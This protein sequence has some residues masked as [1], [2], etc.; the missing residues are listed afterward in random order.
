MRRGV[1]IGLFATLLVACASSPGVTA[2]QRGD[3]AALSAYIKPLYDKGKIDN[4]EAARI[5]KAE[6]ERELSTAKDKDALE[7]LRDAQPCVA[8]I[9]PV[10]QDLAKKHDALGAAAALALYETGN[11]SATRAREWTSDATPEWRAVG[12]RA[13][14]RPEDD[15]ARH[16]ALVDP[17]PEVRRASMRA[18]GQANDPR[19]LDGLFEAARLDPEPMARNEAVRAIARIT[20]NDPQIANRLRDLWTSSDDAVR[21][22]IASAYAAPSIAS[23]GGAEA[24][25][26]LVAAGHGP[27]VISGAAAILWASSHPSNYDAETRASALALLLRTIDSGS[28]RDRS[29]ALAVVPTDDPSA[30]LALQKAS[31]DEGDV[32]VRISA[33]TRLLEVP[34]SRTEALSALEQLAQPDADHPSTGQ[35]ARASLARAGDLHVQAWI[36]KDLADE[37]ASVRLGAVNALAALG[38]PARG[39]PLLA[40]ADP[41]VRTR[42]ACT[43]VVAA[44][45]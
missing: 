14:V 4:D 30:V 31:K 13:L 23:H 35:R 27:G 1:S 24:L 43:I 29:F 37:D 6:L 7:R 40:D 38:R 39:A 25:R 5:A 41:R 10:L 9:E 28:R 12:V 22:D 11:V 34:T 33:L 3:R 45:K 32:D 42:A 16:V 21:E 36:E 2:A 18:S 17:S 8:E 20:S 44:R 19:D 26:V 15:E